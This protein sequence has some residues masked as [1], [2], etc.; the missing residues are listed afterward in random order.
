M[1][2]IV[3][4]AVANS[5]CSEPFLFVFVVNACIKDIINHLF[6]ASKAFTEGSETPHTHSASVRNSFPNGSL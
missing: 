4:S 2:G 6:T 5:F 3:F 1:T